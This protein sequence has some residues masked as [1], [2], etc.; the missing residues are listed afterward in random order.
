MPHRIERPETLRPEELDRYLGQGWYRIGQTLM[1]CRV[2]LTSSVLRSVVWTRVPLR[3]YA[4]RKGLRR[5]MRR[6]GQRFD[7]R[8]APCVV[9]AEREALYRRYLTVARGDRVESLQA[10]RYGARPGHELF[11]T[12]ECAIY[13]GERLVALSWFDRGRTSLQSVVGAYDPEYARYG[14]GFYSMLLEIEYGLQHGYEHFYA[15]YVLPGDPSMDYKLRTGG[16][17]FLDYEAQVWRPWEEHAVYPLPVD[18]LTRALEEARTTLAAVGIES[19]LRLYPHFTLPAHAPQLASCVDQPIVL[20]CAGTLGPVGLVVTWD[21]DREVWRLQ[22]CARAAA[23]FRYADGS[24]QTHLVLVVTAPL[25]WFDST[26]SLARAA[27][28]A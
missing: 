2:L 26:R 24:E 11:D 10:L 14:L 17:E 27:R 16:V 7:V 15:G 28:M 6:R 8:F 4:F 21:F 12:W 3:G 23:E 18:R 5:L 1:T 20:E 25:G 19:R 13:D 9:D 22:R